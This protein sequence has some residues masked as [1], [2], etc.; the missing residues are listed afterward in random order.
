M[1]PRFQREPRFLRL[2]QSGNDKRRRVDERSDRKHAG[3][4]RGAVRASVCD[5]PDA[6][7]DVDDLQ[8]RRLRHGQLPI[9]GGYGRLT[10]RRLSGGHV[11]EIEA[12]C[13]ELRRVDEGQ[14]ASLGTHPIPIERQAHQPLTVQV[15]LQ[16]RVNG[17]VLRGRNQSAAGRRTVR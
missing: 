17:A 13:Q 10:R 4:R 5:S 3:S 9:S 2:A 8:P 12:P 16:L 6:A 15:T 11:Q 7:F 14:F 1:L